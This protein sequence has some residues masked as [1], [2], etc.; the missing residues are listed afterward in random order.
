MGKKILILSMTAGSGHIRAAKALTEYAKASLP[1]ISA[2]HINISDIA[3][4]LIKLFNQDI[5]KASIDNWPKAWG[6][7]Y[8]ASDN[9]PAALVLGKAVS[10]QR[11]FNYK[12]SRYLKSKKPE[13]VI[14]TYSAIAQ[15]MA[16]SFKRYS[17]DMKLSLVVTDYHGHSFYNV[18]NID[19]FFAANE[20]VKKELIH[21]GIR[22]D[23]ILITGIPINPRFYLKQD[24]GEL[25]QKYKIKN[26]LPIVLFISSWASGFSGQRLTET[27]SRLLNFE[28]KINLIFLAN[29]NKQAYEAVLRHFAKEKRLL[30]EVW[31][32]TIDEYMKISD[33]IISKAGGITVSECLSL[34][35][36]MIIFN[37]IPGQEE[38][39]ADFIAENNFGIKVGNEKEI[40]SALPKAMSLLGNDFCFSPSADNPCAKIFRYFV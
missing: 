5:F 27:I 18:P 32:D 1:E 21:A 29:G 34:N 8:K 25:K 28:P 36:P 23:K 35:K 11:P 19:C 14:F 2:E 6:K 15:I 12:V 40:I 7:L 13:G 20:K 24:A 30:S 9:R 4:P 16:A 39:N 37:P 31:T 10:L 26:N 17:P 3:N 38:R 33:I 22:E